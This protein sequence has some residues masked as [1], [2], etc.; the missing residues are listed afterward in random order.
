[1]RWTAGRRRTRRALVLAT[2]ALLGL[3]AQPAAAHAAPSV[4]TVDTQVTTEAAAKGSTTFLVYLKERAHLDQAAKVRGADAR[5]T[6][7]HHQLRD[8]ADRTQAGLRNLLRTK[9][10]AYTPYWIA[11]AI[12]V[13]GDR[14]LLDAIAARSEVARIEPVRQYPVVKPTPGTEAKV[15]T[16]AAEW[17][18]TNIGADR[19]WDE[20]A[21]RGEGIVVANIDGGVQYDHPALVD[22]Y[23]G[24][25]GDGTFTHDYNWYDPSGV[26]GGDAPCD[27]A[28]HGTHT[29]G[30]MVGDGGA[31]NQVGVAPRATWIA[32]KACERAFCSNSSLMLAG[33]WMLAPTDRNGQNPRPDLRPD[34][35]NNSWGG[36]QGDLWYQQVVDAWRAA[37]IFAAFAAGNEGPDCNTANSPSDYPT[38]Y[39]V[40]G[41]NAA[42][43]VYE[44]SS[45]G[46]SGADG[47]IK[48]NISAPAENVRSTWPGSGYE[49]ISGTSMATPHVS[50]AVALIWSAAPSLRGDVAATEKLLNETATD[51]DATECGGTAANNNVFGEGR[52]NAYQAVLKAPRGAVGRVSG[53]VTDA[54]TG[55]PLA[56]VAV[57]AGDVHATT[58]AD[59]GYALALPDGTYSVTALKYGYGSRTATVT[60][61]AG[62][63]HTEN[64]ALAPQPVVTVSG[65][66]TD[67]SGH[68]WPLYA[69]I[70]VGGRPGGPVFTD[71]ITGKFSFTVPADTTYAV[72]TTV[73]YSGYRKV[74]STVRV[75]DE[76]KTLNIK[77]PV[78][79]GC[80]AAGYSGSFSAPLVDTE[81]F[82]AA[83]VPAGWSVRDRTTSPAWAFDD[84]GHRGN[85]TGGSGNFAVADSFRQGSEPQDSDLVSRTYDLSGTRAPYLRFNSDLLA[86]SPED[87]GDV[88]LSLD[89]GTTW[90][91]VWHGDDY[92]TGPRQEVV[93]LEAAAGAAN[94]TLR[95]R[96]QGYYGWWWGVDNVEVVDRVC[97]PTPAGL[98]VGFVTDKNTGSGL[99][100]V[101][102]ASPAAPQQR[103]VTEAT[104]Q[105]ASIGD[106]FYWLTTSLTGTHAFEA[107]KR[108]Y[109]AVAK[110][111][112][113]VADKTTRANIALTAGRVT[114]N[115]SSIE[116]NQPYGGTRSTTVTVKNTGS[117]P[118]TVEVLKRAGQLDA[119]TA[120]KGTPLIEQRVAGVTN[121]R[122]GVSAGSMA[123][124][125]QPSGGDPA[126]SRIANTPAPIYDN[127]AVTFGGKVY[128]LGGQGAE[129]SLW[130]YDPDTNV[131]TALA[132][133]PRGRIQPSAAVVDGKI[134]VLGGWSATG[135]PIPTV[136]VY[137]PTAGTWSTLVGV[138][139]PAPRAAAGT[140]VVGGRIVLVGGC[141]DSDCAESDDVLVFDPTSRTFSS[142]ARYP[143][144][145]SF[146]SCGGI[147]NGVYCAG[148]T[149][150]QTLRSTYG[151]DPAVDAWTQL[152]DLPVE[153]WGAQTAVAGGALILSGGLSSDSTSVT[154]RTVAYDPGT[155]IW[156][157]L[158]NAQVAAFR[159]A[160]AC[161]LYKIGGVRPAGRLSD[162]EHLGGFGGCD[163]VDAPWLATTPAAFTLAAGESKKITVTVTAAPEA[164]ISQ[165]GT[166]RA[167]FGLLTDT[168]YP[169]P[170]VDVA[171]GVSVPADWGKIQGTVTGESCAGQ[172]LPLAA[173][174][175]LNLAGTGGKT[176]YTVLADSQ[177]R[178]VHWLPAGT[179]QAVVS[180]DGWTSVAKRRTVEA[181]ITLTYDVALAPA[182][183]CGSRLGGI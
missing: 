21:D 160:M 29:M 5:A 57:A 118:A 171:V 3:V 54:A 20:F 58:G 13:T 114:V 173:S 146:V 25:N 49:T 84:P 140:A 133:M 177:G 179:Y 162:A 137:D 53:T 141:V 151:Y 138:L 153:V 98:V 99:V 124:V 101:S 66:V 23:R 33:Q 117:A 12:Q 157:Q 97:V 180:R 165:P 67:G 163:T 45:R 128:S 24:N 102:V 103:A 14:A 119:L 36:G 147:G 6:E 22:T 75:T 70:E 131:W 132:E 65:R 181:G 15:A 43:Q 144:T 73:R 121:S 100:G 95:F 107:A 37:G 32:A 83:T 93:P 94:V 42:N 106:G 174:V 176:G 183:P 168:P 10:A 4:A 159:G 79:H 16:A 149:N 158:P 50:G 18:V 166:Y 19:V 130:R 69:S 78:D 108:P 89:G 41:Y 156:K 27:T 63:S 123:S 154:N 71:P 116:M 145:V 143:V 161:G 35:V 34:V 56:G 76:A 129:R 148:G 44:Y 170:A 155:R 150:G 112:T 30:T 86:T 9:R 169:V 110:D 120:Q 26:C 105:D 178:Y 136:D 88:D 172:R 72:G 85:N 77:V 61:V 142:G 135:A 74:F 152:P 46:S 55:A 182:T 87:M 39:A 68:G 80:T 52:L 48:P 96:Y 62:R 31:G 7:V 91:N 111:V 90:Q 109:Q 164:G 1:M 82:D 11:N 8:T 92:R 139:S 167:E 175:R 51:V 104:P 60:A 28:G 64:F 47:G 38:S 40:G 127:A 81:T 113:V 17:G 126:W 122:T 115:Q 59:G 2:V 134:Y 125:S